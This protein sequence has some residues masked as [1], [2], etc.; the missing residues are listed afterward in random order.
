MAVPVRRG[1]HGDPARAH[2][3]DAW[4][5]GTAR[6]PGVS[7][8]QR[9]G[10][11]A[12]GPWEPG[13]GLRFN[14]AQAAA[15]PL[16]PRGQRPVDRD[17]RSRTPDVPASATTATR[18]RTSPAAWSCTTT[19]TGATTAKLRPA[20]ARHRRSTS[21]TSRASPR[22]TTGC[23]S[24]LRG[25]YAGLAHP[26]VT[27]YLHDLGV[28]AVELLPVHQFTSEPDVVERGLTNY[29]GYNTIGFFAPHAAYSS[30]GDRG[31]QV[32]RVQGRWSRRC[33]RP[34]SR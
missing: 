4:A 28:T 9:Y 32:T 33:T 23:P 18:R 27:D 31:Q 24:E 19:S 11:R 20:L 25:T 26:A 3:A 14:P 8:G 13:L 6:C 7:V 17:T 16:R 29:W 30:S 1:R 21:C 22:C 2:R 12:D 5:S 15:R 10:F 34:G